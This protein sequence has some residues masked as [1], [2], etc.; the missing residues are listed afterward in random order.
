[1]EPSA[2]SITRRA[3]LVGDRVLTA[4]DPDAVLKV[5][6]R[7]VPD[8]GAAKARRIIRLAL[9]RPAHVEILRVLLGGPATTREV[10]ESLGWHASRVGRDLR[11]LEDARL[12]RR[13]A[14]S[15]GLG[16][17]IWHCRGA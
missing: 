2:A 7:L 13:E 3:L 14:R 4:T 5:V 10:A 1:M 12:V 8:V 15:Q 6:R 11:M 9:L 17:M 16:G